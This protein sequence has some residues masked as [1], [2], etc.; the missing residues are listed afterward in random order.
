MIESN[1]M[2]ACNQCHV[3]QPI[4]WTLTHLKNWYGKT[5]SDRAINENYPNRKQPTAINWLSSDND[6]VRLVAADSLSRVNARWALPQLIQ[7]L[8]DPFLLNRQFARIGL[9]R[10]LKRKLSDFGYQFYQSK[11]ERTVPLRRLKEQLL[12]ATAEADVSPSVVD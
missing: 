6:S 11:D 4:D 5:F 10:M 9:E 12:P 3:E 8:D 1:Q 2:N 7:G